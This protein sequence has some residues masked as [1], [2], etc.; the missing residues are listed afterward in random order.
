MISYY[1]VC[2]DYGYV[3]ATY[4]G[5]HYSISVLCGKKGGSLQ[6]FVTFFHSANLFF[7]NGF[8]FFVLKDSVQYDFFC[9]LGFGI[10]TCN[11]IEASLSR[12][13]NAGNRK[14]WFSLLLYVGIVKREGR[15]LKFLKLLHSALVGKRKD[16]K[17]RKNGDGD[18]IAW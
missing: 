5:S 2:W 8:R 13:E 17:E 3:L 7:P 11:I 9:M 4:Y 18:G 6:K 14:L 16:F 10:Y 1:F 12:R 15:F